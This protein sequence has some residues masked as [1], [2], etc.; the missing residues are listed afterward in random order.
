MRG[1][2][3]KVSGSRVGGVRVGFSGLGRRDVQQITLAYSHLM[4]G[5]ISFPYGTF[6]KCLG[7]KPCK[8]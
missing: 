4:V 7:P 6:K 2:G 3:I 1:V 5:P 8:P